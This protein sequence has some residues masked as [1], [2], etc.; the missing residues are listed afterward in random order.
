MET[1]NTNIVSIVY[2]LLLLN[3][4]DD[5]AFREFSGS[6]MYMKQ[7]EKN[8]TAA[9]VMISFALMMRQMS[10]SIVAPFLSTYCRTL[11]GY[12]PFAA[13]LTLGVFGLMQAFLQTPFGMLS[14]RYGRK[15]VLLSGLALTVAGL[16]LAW[17]AQSIAMLIFA[18]ALQG[19][20]AVIG[21]GYAWAAG[22][23]P[24]THRTKA[25]GI[26]SLMVSS[27]A[28]AAFILGPLLRNILAVN[29]IFLV[30]AAAISITALYIL[31]FIPDTGRVVNHKPE[32]AGAA[33]RLMKNG[34][35]MKICLSAFLNNFMMMSVFFAVPVWLTGILPET[36]MWIVFVPA[37]A[38]AFFAM[39]TAVHITDNGSG[40]NVLTGAFLI[41]SMGILLFIHKN[42]L[43]FLGAGT[44]V[45]FG[46]Y[47]S[48]AAVTASEINRVVPD[49]LRGTGNG[50]FNA[51]QYLGSFTGAA[52]TGFIWNFSST[53]ACIPAFCA[54]ITGVI[55]MCTLRRTGKRR[56]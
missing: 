44:T 23:A 5:S 54:G 12:T 2:Y 27:G 24:E 3:Q 11:P 52:V 13:G 22:L 32:N 35:F 16:V 49:D 56:I 38:C 26:L 30:C 9:V 33:G 10:M 46:S 50:I 55:L 36:G 34:N 6:E 4:P 8:M 31:F 21:V 51:I 47:A 41:S 28:A 42:S 53:A 48:I 43:L 25:M 1:I 14:D 37:I 17:H 20:G 45:F 18:R 15:R 40:R 39:K 29:Q 19:S 7:N